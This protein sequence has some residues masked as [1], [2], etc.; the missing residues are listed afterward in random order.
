MF[1]VPKNYAIVDENVQLP[2][3][4]IVVPCY[5][6][7]NRDEFLELIEEMQRFGGLY[8]EN[9]EVRPNSGTLLLH[10]LTDEEGRFLAGLTRPEHG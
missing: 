9:T 3:D 4:V 7:S 8:V 1:E 2:G 6:I 5:Q 10:W